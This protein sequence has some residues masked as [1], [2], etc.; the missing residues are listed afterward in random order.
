MDGPDL[1]YLLD[2]KH[3]GVFQVS[4]YFFNMDGHDV[5]SRFRDYMIEVYPSP[6][7]WRDKFDDWVMF[8]ELAEKQIAKMPPLAKS[9]M[10]DFWGGVHKQFILKGPGSYFV[11][12]RRNYSFNT[13]LSGIMIQQVHGAPTLL[14]Q[15]INN[16]GLYGMQKVDYCP[17]PFP[18]DI[19]HEA[20]R[21]TYRL[22]NLLDDKYDSVGNIKY[23]RPYRI[24]TFVASDR[25]SNEGE[26]VGQLAESI[27]WRLNQWDAK[28]RKEFEETMLQGWKE[29]F[30]A[31]ASLRELIQDNKAR[32]PQIYK[33]SYYDESFYP[34]LQS[35][36]K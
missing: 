36:K 28:Q 13:M 31:N 17:P 4:M 27:K 14:Q 11:K 16:N 12:I 32:F 6:Q 26:D 8:S 1:W 33:E 24:A 29:Y 30:R 15:L 10:H 19:D 3:P 23:Q 2:I 18:E 35:Q 5:H 7:K 20:G 25:I 34:E 22:W 21:Q 9:R